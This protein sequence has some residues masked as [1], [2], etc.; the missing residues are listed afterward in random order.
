MRN[1]HLHVRTEPSKSVKT[2]RLGNL[3]FRRNSREGEERERFNHM[4]KWVWRIKEGEANDYSV[5]P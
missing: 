3:Y 1:W 5:G 4:R 2:W